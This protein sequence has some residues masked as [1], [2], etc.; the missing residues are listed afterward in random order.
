MRGSP[1]QTET[2]GAS[3]SVAAPR[4]SARGMTCFSEVEYSRMRPQPVQVRLQV[5]SGSSC[6]TIANFGVRRVLC[7]M[8]CP[9][10]FAV[11]ANG[12]LIV[13][14]QGEHFARRSRR[15]GFLLRRSLILQEAGEEK[16]R[17]GN[18]VRST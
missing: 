18:A 2:M 12:N 17:R 16:R 10:I 4:Q 11:S 7:L 8:M 9:A 5:C 6:N 3:H 13:L 15:N 1:P 14:F